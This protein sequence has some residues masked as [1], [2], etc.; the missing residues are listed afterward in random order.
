MWYRRP[1]S[2]TLGLDIGRSAV[3]A[4]AMDHAGGL[5]EIIGCHEERW[6]PHAE[7]GEAMTR[8]PQALHDALARTL[9]QLRGIMPVHRAHITT[10]IYGPGVV[11]RPLAVEPVAP[12]QVRELL[13]WE[14]EEHL[15]FPAEDTVFDHVLL[16]KDHA[17]E[18]R[19]LLVAVHRPLVTSRLELLHAAGIK[20][21][22]IT[23]DAL[24]TLNACRFSDPDCAVGHVTLI[25][26]TETHLQAVLLADGVPTAVWET[27]RMRAATSEDAMT[28]AI[29]EAVQRCE[30]LEIDRTIAPSPPA[31]LRAVWLR[32]DADHGHALV[33]AVGIR[34]QC[35]VHTMSAFASLPIRPQTAGI[36]GAEG[37][38][39]RFVVAC[40]LALQGVPLTM[41][42]GGPRAAH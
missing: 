17:G 24:A 15:P 27:E 30:E 33:N 38:G 34:L 5:P 26:L 36:T 2:L 32:S 19:V 40:G 39:G 18:M 10:A 35:P 29:V 9:D 21:A 3:R 25:T 12:H 16:P 4:L 42:A 6:E 14:T 1:S 23:V 37:E 28:D 41:T 7:F 13:R 22:A 31:P 20:R 8:P 11:V